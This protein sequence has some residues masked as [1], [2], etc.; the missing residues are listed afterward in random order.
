MEARASAMNDKVERVIREYDD[1]HQAELRLMNELPHDEMRRRIHEFLIP[2]GHDTGRFLHDLA[3]ASRSK[4]ILEFG[5]SYGYSA[6][7]LAAAARATGG[8]VI[9]LDL[10]AEKQKYAREKLDRAG[11]L[12]H[13]E[14]ISGDALMLVDQLNGPFDFVLIDFA[15]N[16]YIPCFDA[17]VPKLASPAFV[18]ADNMLVPA[19]SLAEAERYR[20]HVRHRVAQTILLPLGT[21]IELSRVDG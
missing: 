14:F 5:T 3:V 16:L 9:S 13:V 1:R 17:I 10:S 18:V 21:G 20:A 7:W 8:K 15:K 2:I 11:L 12:D 6:V 4:L 19:S